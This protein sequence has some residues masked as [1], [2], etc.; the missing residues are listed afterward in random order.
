M[1]RKIPPRVY[2]FDHLPAAQHHLDLATRVGSDKA[3]T[4]VEAAGSQEAINHRR[5]GC[6][7]ASDRVCVSRP[8]GTPCTPVEAAIFA[9]FPTGVR[10]SDARSGKVWSGGS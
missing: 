2:T 10:P 7:P 5:L 1:K 6:R 4:A 8:A 3:P 9:C